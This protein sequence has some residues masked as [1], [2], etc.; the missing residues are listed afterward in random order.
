MYCLDCWLLR[1]SDRLM[2]AARC[3]WLRSKCLVVT[4]F[5]S[6]VTTT[7]SLWWRRAI[8]R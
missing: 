6:S 4:T 1:H 3:S 5:R 8:I 2:R 7:A